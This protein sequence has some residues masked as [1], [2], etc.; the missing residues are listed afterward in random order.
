MSLKPWRN[1]AACVFVSIVCING[2]SK[3]VVTEQV[4]D[5]VWEIAMAATKKGGAS[6]KRKLEDVSEEPPKKSAKEEEPEADAEEESADE[7]ALT[8]TELVRFPHPL[9]FQP[10]NFVCKLA[11][12]CYRWREPYMSLEMVTAASSALART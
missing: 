11:S 4:L 6:R 3:I 7:G 1:V 5:L 10:H 2:R 12:G 9:C 8:R